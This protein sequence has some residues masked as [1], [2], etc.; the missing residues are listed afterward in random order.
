[1]E[2]PMDRRPPLTE[3]QHEALSFISSFNRKFGF[4]PSLREIGESMG[5]TST[6]GVSDHLKA[7]EKKGYIFR[8]PIKSRA[9]I[10]VD[11]MLESQQDRITK[12]EASIIL[13]AL[14]AFGS[15]SSS[16]Q[17]QSILNKLRRIAGRTG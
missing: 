7:L 6:N 16:T 2:F 8:E 13:D 10:V 1:M 4:P 5:I 11:D 12:E 17:D 3:R 9:I 15:G 14:S